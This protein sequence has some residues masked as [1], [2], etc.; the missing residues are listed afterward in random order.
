MVQSGS[1]HVTP[2]ASVS[3]SPSAHVTQQRLA[4]YSGRTLEGESIALSLE[5]FTH[6]HNHLYMSISYERYLA[7]RFRSGRDVPISLKVSGLKTAADES[8]KGRGT[9]SEGDR[10]DV[11]GSHDTQLIVT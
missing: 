6:G 3:P 5:T 8:G 9:G 7:R 4:K 10:K 1:G 2:T 11:C